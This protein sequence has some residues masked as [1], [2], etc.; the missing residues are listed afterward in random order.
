MTNFKLMLCVAA[1]A[2]L[3]ACAFV[4][5]VSLHFHAGRVM[6]RSILCLNNDFPQI[7]CADDIFVPVDP[8][9]NLLFPS[10]SQGSESLRA[11]FVVLRF[12]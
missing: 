3:Q 1:S 12:Q 4:P 5:H 10:D 9:L 11:K 2:A 8:S 7:Q 6:P